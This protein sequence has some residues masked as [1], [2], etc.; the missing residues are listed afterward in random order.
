[1]GHTAQRQCRRQPF[2]D[3]RRGQSAILQA[4]R[5]FILDAQSTELVLRVLLHEA[6][7]VGDVVEWL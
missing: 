6:D 1:V 2:F 3:L 5:H 7:P 4:E